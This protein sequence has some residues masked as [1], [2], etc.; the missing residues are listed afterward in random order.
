MGLLWDQ[1]EAEMAMK[2][3]CHSGKPCADSEV[4][5]ESE[6]HPGS[7]GGPVPPPPLP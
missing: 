2:P 5:S 4:D 7:G 3:P 1:L 6:S